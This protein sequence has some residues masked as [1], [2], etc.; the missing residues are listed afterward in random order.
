MLDAIFQRF[1]AES[2]ISVMVRALMESVLAPD[3]I[4]G[5]VETEKLFELIVCLTYEGQSL[6]ARRIVLNLFKPTR[7]AE[8]EI[9]ILTGFPRFEAWA[10]V[11]AQLDRQRRSVKNLFQ[12]VTKNYESEIQTLGYRKAA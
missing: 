4:D 9:A 8:K 2:P 11:V 7:N 12:Y 3:K 10:K 6:L 1:A 5:K